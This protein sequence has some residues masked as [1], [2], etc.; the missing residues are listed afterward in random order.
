MKY[1]SIG[2]QLIAKAQELDPNY[3]PD[4]F[5]DMSEA[6]DILLNNSGSGGGI[7]VVEG[8][9]SATATDGAYATYTIPEAQTSCF[10]FKCDLGTAFISYNDV[11]GTYN[12]YLDAEG[13]VTDGS[14]KLNDLIV[15]S[16]SGTTINVFFGNI[17]S[18][19]GGSS[20]DIV[21]INVNEEITEKVYSKVDTSGITSDTRFVLINE[22]FG[23]NSHTYLLSKMED[24]T[25]GNYYRMPD[26]LGGVGKGIIL[27]SNGVIKVT[28]FNAVASSSIASLPTDD[29]TPV[30]FECNLLTRIGSSIVTL[31][32]G[33]G[34][35]YISLV[36]SK[37]PE[38]FVSPLKQRGSNYVY[39]YAK[40]KDITN[41]QLYRKTLT[42]S[43]GVSV[44]FED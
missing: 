9:E 16:G 39:Y 28:V 22:K 18:G 21:T 32:I 37:S 30:M 41:M 10:I 33:G 8:T 35:E 19:G 20:L 12:G 14:L 38:M 36:K 11:F 25:F 5:N 29:T 13:D 43:G 31:N 26:I 4:K 2:E 15:L 40:V 42:L 17:A 23:A 34:D 24:S 3:K 6:I 7:P 1:N 27:D 44:T